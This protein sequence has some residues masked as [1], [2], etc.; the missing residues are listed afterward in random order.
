MKRLILILFLLSSCTIN[1]NK[2]NVAEPINFDK[3]Y[4]ISEYKKLLDLY[5]DKKGY[6]N[7]DE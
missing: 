6:P 4:S 3:D 2:L 7:I 1:N 5:N